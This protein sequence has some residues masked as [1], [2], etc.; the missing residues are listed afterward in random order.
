[1]SNI[2]I[3]FD[4]I[5]KHNIMTDY[6]TRKWANEDREQY[7]KMKAAKEEQERW[8]QEREEET[9]RKLKNDADAAAFKAKCTQQDLQFVTDVKK[10][11]DK[12]PF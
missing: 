8:Q 9:V 7:E 5:K 12:L 1:L 3:E 11:L 2:S 4:L 6:L 10:L